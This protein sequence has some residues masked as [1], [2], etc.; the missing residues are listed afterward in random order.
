MWVA[1]AQLRLGQEHDF[2][3]LG[4]AAAVLFF[5]SLVIFAAVIGL[6]FWVG[7]WWT[8][9]EGSRSP[10]AGGVLLRGD[11][12][13]YTATEAVQDYMSSLSQDV[14]P[15]F[16]LKNA[17]ICRSTGRIFPDSLNRWGAAVVSWNFLQKRHS[18]QWQS[19]GSLSPEQQEYIRAWHGSLEGYQTQF[20]SSIQ[21]PNL[22]ERKYAL[23]KPGPLYV[24]LNTKNL[25]GW[26]KVPQTDLEVLVVQLPKKKP[27]HF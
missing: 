11:I 12:L 24:D 10:Y 27:G 3:E 18:G 8:N 6:I 21:Q 14:N 16:S 1:L 17:A 7:W 2:A 26:Q 15:L 9:R 20:S 25:L 5:I 13:S 19:W 22:V 4:E 23:A